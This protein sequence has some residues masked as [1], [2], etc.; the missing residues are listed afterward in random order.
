M[1]LSFAVA[2]DAV[3]V[4]KFFDLEA[5]LPQ[6]G[7]TLYLGVL[8]AVGAFLAVRYVHSPWRKLPPGPKG[9]PV[10]GNFIELRNKQWLT[11][12][13]LS[14]QYG[15]LIYLNVGGQPL[16]VVNSLKVTAD[17]LDRRARIYSDRPRNIV[18]SDILTGG[19][20]IVFAHHGD[21]WRRMRKA[22]HE[23]LSKGIARG[24][25]DIQARESVLL[26]SI[27]LNDPV[28]WDQHFR[29]A[30]TSSI[31]SITYDL[32]VLESEDDPRVVR[33]NDYVG[34]LTR[35][36][37][38]GAH[39][40]E[41]FPW[42][43]Y[44]PSRLAKWKRDGYYWYEQD[45]L[46][47]EGLLN[48]VRAEVAEG[49]ERPSFCSSLI[50][51]QARFGISQRES[52]WLAGTLYSAGAETT[53]AVLSWWALAMIAFPETQKRAQQDLDRVVGRGR[54]PTF[55][56]L[57][58]L[59]YIQAMVKETLRW[60]PVAPVGL[61]HRSTEDDW[62]EGMFIPKGTIVIANVWKMNH[63]P[64][65]FG[66]NADI[67]DPA[68]HLDADGA[69]VPGVADTK[70][71]SHVAYGFGRRICVGR[72]LANNSLFINMAVLLWAANLEGAKDAQGR[73]AP[74]DVDGCLEGGL[75]VRPVPFECSITPRF[76][77]ALTVLA[78]ER[79]VR[80]I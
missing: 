14:K 63:D 25:Y 60:R 36:A 59:P 19:Q 33:I 54:V 56:D 29:R 16:L 49:S 50:K 76:S 71:E 1:P 64:E 32:P 62:Y 18:A 27:A 20:L 26:A 53:A 4:P 74:I 17:L 45:S 73:P 40:V 47:F 61:P 78:G 6:D 68:R 41:F 43:K 34:R 5:L 69:L 65:L 10:V 23:A 3:S 46:M 12:T 80:G 2:F 8:V 7:V 13:E 31:L 66:A 48:K 22:A 39:W 21:V 38:P 58:H 70:D 72:H 75:V 28:K 51:E 44:I 15:D 67:F 52:A 55:A 37:F 24:Y 77:E 30:S 42:M 11:F 79:D 35:A 57:P 9:F